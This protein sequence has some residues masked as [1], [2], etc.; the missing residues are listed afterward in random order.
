MTGS[1]PSG[2]HWDQAYPGINATALRYRTSGDLRAAE[3]VY[4]QGL[5]RALLRDDRLATVRFLMSV[6]GCRLLRFEYRSALVAFLDAR[7]RAFAI[8]DTVDSGAIAVN[9][10][11]IYLQMWDISSA[12]RAAEQG[13]DASA[14]V[15]GAYFVP[16]LL[17]Q[18]GR[19]EAM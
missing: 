19:L 15:P 16:Q 14:K 1:R 18:L 7:E 11:S 5:G 13:L 4:Q 8:D 3:R 6:G 10:S 9:I 17:L 2:S 12:Q